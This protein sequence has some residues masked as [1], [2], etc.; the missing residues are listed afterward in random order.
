MDKKLKKF[1]IESESVVCLEFENGRK[2]RV[3]RTD[4]SKYLVGEDLR[5]VREGFK[6]RKGYFGKLP[7]WTGAFAF[8]AGVIAFAV[9]SG[10]VAQIFTPRSS[11]P[12][13]TEQAVPLK[14]EA[15]SKKP[16]V[17]PFPAGARELKTGDEQNPAPSLRREEIR[18]ENARKDS[19][20]SPKGGPKAEKLPEQASPA[21]TQ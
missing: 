16:A 11:N 13:P 20:S 10:G 2:E 3:G 12:S 5:R 15:E 4:L 1:S 17:E 21:R 8:T 7:K 18:R 9:Q 19:A 14:G 6:L